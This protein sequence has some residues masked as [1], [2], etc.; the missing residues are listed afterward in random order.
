MLLCHI[1]WLRLNQLLKSS[2]G[3]CKISLKT[4]KIRNMM[5]YILKKQWLSQK[6]TCVSALKHIR[7]YMKSEAYGNCSHV[8]CIPEREKEMLF[9]IKDFGWS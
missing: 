6:N 9:I 7:N 4:C 8:L 1:L 3:G 5:K 2:R